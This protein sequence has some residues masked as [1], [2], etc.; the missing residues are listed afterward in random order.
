MNGRANPFPAR[1]EPGRSIDATWFED[2]LGNPYAVLFA[3]NEAWLTWGLDQAWTDNEPLAETTGPDG[4][5][6][7]EG[8]VQIT[9]WPDI[10]F[11]GGLTYQSLVTTDVA[12]G[13]DSQFWSTNAD[14]GIA[15]M[16]ATDL[17]QGAQIDCL[18]SGWVAAASS[19]SIAPLDGAVWATLNDE[20]G[21]PYGGNPG[22]YPYIGILRTT[23]AGATWEYAG[24]GYL[25]ASSGQP[26]VST[27]STDG[28]LR[29]CRDHDLLQ[30]G[31]P[32]DLAFPF[33]SWSGSSW[34][35]ATT[36]LATDLVNPTVASLPSLG[37][38][39]QVEALNAAS[40]LVLVAAEVD[41]GSTGNAGPTDSYTTDGGLLLT[42][43]GGVTW[44]PVPFDGGPA[45]CDART[46]WRHGR[47]AVVHP[48]TTSYW[49]GTTSS[50]VTN[51][52]LGGAVPVLHDYT[53][54]TPDA[55]DPYHYDIFLALTQNINGAADGRYG[56]TSLASSTEGCELAKVS[57]SP[58]ASGGVA[59]TWTWIP[60][61]IQ[62]DPSNPDPPTCGI[63]S[64]N[65]AGLAVAPWSNDLVLWGGYERIWQ[66][67]S[68]FERHAGGVCTMPV[69]LSAGLSQV[70]D[71]YSHRYS[72]A[73]VAPHPE[74]ADLYAV[75]PKFDG[76]DWSG[77]C[78]DR[79]TTTG[80]DPGGCDNFPVPSLL[81]QS[82]AGTWSWRSLNDN[83]PTSRA[84]SAAW[85]PV[86]IYEGPRLNDEGS[87]SW[88][89][90]G[91]S[92]SGAWRGRVGW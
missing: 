6:Q 18:W 17:T 26:V 27:W 2:A 85:S 73:E 41:A 30:P 21:G 62:F 49:H 69:D 90:V 12:V 75:V 25:D 19:V 47:F 79:R 67:A 7:P 91:T 89:Y 51:T 77:Q 58:D 23:D 81:W 29:A 80:A 92:G 74:M 59:A 87:A 68:T 1:T 24:A 11:A 53:L 8:D 9:F 57:I 46:T 54:Y 38:P 70:L 64:D 14:V 88:L 5:L 45:G 56:H 84:E 37:N 43:D 44:A 42:I 83:F 71:P 32:Y 39:K 3:G 10:D 60:L 34:D 4:D 82:G 76:A 52:E 33:A 36:A 63:Y 65:I 40:A 78:Q 66:G 48:G 86:D 22:A 55:Q 16:D 31:P 15:Q 61:S 20:A 13:A 50:P 28:R 72:I 35:Y